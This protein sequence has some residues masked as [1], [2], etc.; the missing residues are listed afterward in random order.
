MRK[1]KLVFFT[2]AGISQ[3]SGLATF[4]DS[5]G[6][7]EKYRIEDVATP[8]AWKRNPEL[9]TT[10][11]NLRRKQLLEAHP[12]QAHIAIA[13]MER[14]FDVQIITQNVDDLHER[15]GSTRVLHLHGELMKVRSEKF[16]ELI[17]PCRG[18]EVNM[19]DICERGAQLRP[20]VVWFGEQVPNMELAKTMVTDA[21][22]FVVVGTSLEVYPAAFLIHDAPSHAAIYLIDPSDVSLQIGRDVVHIKERA[23]SGMA[24]LMKIL[25]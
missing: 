9:V 6:L 7:W 2:G 4:R 16:P 19:G 18:W 25:Q 24:R 23:T 5:G 21:D 20:H 13:H 22:I 1:L 10:F 8:D 14:D 11:Y 15:A 3:E 12:N 17:Y